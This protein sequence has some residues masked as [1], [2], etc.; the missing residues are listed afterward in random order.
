MVTR[1]PKLELPPAARVVAQKLGFTEGPAVMDDLSLAVVSI[2]RGCVYRV[3]L[4]GS[5]P[6]LIVE[7]GGGPNGVAVDALGALWFAQNGGSAMAS[8]SNLAT[9]P[10][11][12]RWHNGVLE[13]VVS[14]GLISPSDCVFG[15][16]GRLW[17][18][19]PADHNLQESSPTGR[20]MAFDPLSGQLQTAAEDLR[21]PNGLA[22]GA[23]VTNLYVAETANGSVRRFAVTDD[24]CSPDG[25]SVLMPGW[26]P[27][28][29]ALDEAGWLW[30]A[31]SSGDDV[32]AI[33]PAG[34]V[35]HRVSF[36]TGVMVTSVCFAGPELDQMVVTIA[37]GGTVAALPAVHPGL[38]VPLRR[39]GH[40]D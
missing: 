8:K 33:D 17:F 11:L 30:V 7:T 15:P 24:E 40:T 6:D 12:Q 3:W 28:G 38:P 26:R 21:F 39:A 25:W 2:N 36:G 9:G 16:D 20:V 18:T 31:G 34:A 35:R 10:S 1:P 4:D 29:M 14:S 22:F 27:D 23:D 13:T 5:S 32:V 37:K 19:D